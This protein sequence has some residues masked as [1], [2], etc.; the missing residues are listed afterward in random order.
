MQI[1]KRKRDDVPKRFDPGILAHPS[2]ASLKRGQFIAKWGGVCNECGKTYDRNEI[3]HYVNSKVAH[4][5]CH[6]FSKTAIESDEYDFD[7][8]SITEREP[9]Y[10][11]RGKRKPTLCGTCFLEHSGECP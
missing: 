4:A 11:V 1:G 3:M 9:G 10:V 8:P 5:S 6:G 2:A 7:A